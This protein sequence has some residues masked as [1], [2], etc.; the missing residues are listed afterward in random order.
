MVST[1]QYIKW[2]VQGWPPGFEGGG[3]IGSSCSGRFQRVGMVLASVPG[4]VNP[5]NRFWPES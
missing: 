4:K 2:G 3:G 1:T 5:K